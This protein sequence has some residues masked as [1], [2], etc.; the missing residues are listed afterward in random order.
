MDEQA[1]LD[2]L[3]FS[4]LEDTSLRDKSRFFLKIL[5]VYEEEILRHLSLQ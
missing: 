2:K 4:S 3:L 5:D 1:R